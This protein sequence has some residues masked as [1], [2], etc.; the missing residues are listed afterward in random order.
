[1]KTAFAS[2]TA[3][4][5]AT[6]VSVL[7]FSITAQIPPPVDKPMVGAR[8]PALSP[9][10]HRLAFVYRGDVWIAPAAG[11]HAKPITAHVD[12]DAYPVFSP[13]GQWIAFASRRHG[14]WD[15]FVVPAEG[16]AP[17]QLTWHSGHET[18]TGWSPDGK[19]LLFSS[20]RDT[21]DYALYALDVATLRPRVLAEDFAP[22]SSASFSSDGRQVIYGRYGSPSFPW[23]RARYQGSAA[24]K[25]WV[26]DLDGTSRRALSTNGFQHLWTRLLPGAKEFICVTCREA[27]PSASNLNEPPVCWRDNPDRTPNLWAFDLKGRARRLTSF[28]G[29]AVRWPSVAG[30]SGDIAF[31]YGPDLYRLRKGEGSPEKVALHG[32]GDDKENPRRREQLKN[33]V[34]EAEPSPDGNSI[35]FG[36]R[37]DLW[38]IA[39]SKPKGVAARSAELARRLT[40]WAG[41]DSD[42]VWSN[43]GKKLFFTSDREANTR[44]YE[45]DLESLNVRPLWSRDDDVSLPRLSPDG[46][47]LGFLVAGKEGGIYEITLE[48]GETRRLAHVPGPQWRG[49]GAGEFVWS[50]DLK[51]LAFTQ[52]D[53]SKAW[54]IFILPAAGGKAVNVT[55]LNA[56]HG[57]PVWSPDGRYL[58]FQSNRDG[59]GLY[60]L[61]LKPESIRAEDTDVKF[62]KS[63]NAATVEIDFQDPDRR[64]RKWASQNPQSDLTMTSDG[65]FFYLAEGDIWSL[66][67]D[68]KDSKRLTTGGGKTALRPARDRKKVFF[69]QNGELWTLTVENKSTEKVSFTA[70]WE[71]D[72]A[73]ERRAAFVQFWRSY[74]RGFYDA[75]FHGRNWDAIRRQYEPLLESIETDD[76]FAVLLNMMVG[77]LEA[78]HSEVSST[79]RSTPA[80]VTPHLG[81]TFDYS[82]PGPGLKVAEVP[83]GAPGSYEQTRIRP[84]EFVLAINGD[85]VRLDE[86]LYDRLNDKQGRDFEFLVSTNLDKKDARKVTYKVLSQDEWRKLDYDNRVTETRRQVDQKSGGRVGYLHLA[87]MGSGNRT[88]FDRQAYARMIDKEALI[89]DVRFNSGGNIADSLIDWLERKP[90]GYVR[91]RDG[92]VELAPSEA[93]TRPVVVLINEHSFSN[94]ELFAS[95]IRTRRIARLVGMPTP[96]YVIWTDGLKLVDGTNARMPQT[97]AWRLDGTPFENHGEVPDVMVPL[98][99][100][101]RQAG[102]DPQLDKALELLGYRRQ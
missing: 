28:T 3:A 29:G 45:L 25:P 20:R 96:G 44:L 86:Q 85:D 9:D 81:F 43:D 36:L 10:G 8:M 59:D 51:W 65:T 55:R 49:R 1:M 5:L 102:R 61:P 101:D 99:Y 68:G 17:R 66:S 84:G 90:H 69:L 83:D 2:F 73:A 98:S 47:S 57:Q 48:N 87:A 19:E 88:D 62:Q 89:I 82:H 16:G 72:V 50:P 58:F 34:T 37:G 79:D 12:Y 39:V 70:D 41:D 63:T 56:H 4:A 76:E 6:A 11:G 77:E 24:T 27:T 26:L 78:S 92:E 15:L 32:S 94:A 14:N 38:T 18:P 80:V 100:E 95:A 23:T 71:R 35:A 31:E 21:A 67:F 91:A 93:W 52:R 54:N 46:K 60:A 74:H 33:G 40:D 64:I 30:G 42:F 7:P 97:G 75:N 13:D 22:F 53:D